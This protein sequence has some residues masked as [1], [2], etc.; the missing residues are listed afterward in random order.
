[1]ILQEEKKKKRKKR[2]VSLVPLGVLF[3]EETQK[4]ER[5]SPSL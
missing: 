4:E 2:D 3:R 1:M 5:K